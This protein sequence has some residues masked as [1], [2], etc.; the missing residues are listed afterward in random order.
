MWFYVVV[1]LFA[2]FAL[3]DDH[4][5]GEGCELDTEAGDNIHQQ[6]HILSSWNW[7]VTGINN[8]FSVLLLYLNCRLRRKAEMRFAP[9]LLK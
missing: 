8:L 2:D 3:R 6:P 9:E 4:S 5:G 7:N 1:M